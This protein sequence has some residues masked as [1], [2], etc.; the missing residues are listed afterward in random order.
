MGYKIFIIRHTSSGVFHYL[1][2]NM[3]NYSFINAGDGKH[4]HP[5]QG[6]LDAFTLWEKYGEELSNKKICIVGDLLHSRVAKSN[7]EILTKLGVQISTCGPNTLSL[8]GELYKHL[9]KYKNI[10]DAVENNDIIMELRIQNERLESAMMANEAEFHKYFGLKSKH[11]IVKKDLIFM[12]P[13][14]VNYGVEIAKD[15][16]DHPNSLI[17][18]QVANG[19]FIRMAILDTII[20]FYKSKI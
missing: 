15:L 11:F 14:P 1:C 4:K 8:H 3:P 17:L 10:D 13:G 18:K 7:I 19:V 2:E 20:N 5:S 6:L 9:V 16:I 12:H